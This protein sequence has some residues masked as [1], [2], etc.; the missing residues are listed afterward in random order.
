MEWGPLGR[1]S[2]RKGPEEKQNLAS[3]FPALMGPPTCRQGQP[4]GL[5]SQPHHPPSLHW[6]AGGLWGHCP[7]VKALT[8]VNEQV[9]MC[10]VYQPRA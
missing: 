2:G 1:A 7:P 4:P 8:G 9:I 6:L 10:L 3:D 5:P